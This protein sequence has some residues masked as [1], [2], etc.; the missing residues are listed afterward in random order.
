MVLLRSLFAAFVLMSVPPAMADELRVQA[1]Q[2]L[3]AAA[4]AGLAPLLAPHAGKP[5][6]INFWASWCEPC[7]EEIPALAALHA[8]GI[9]VLTVAVADRDTDAQR[10]LGGAGPGLP[11]THDRDQKLSRALGVALL[12]YSLVLDARHRVVAR[13][14]GALDWTDASVIATL[15][16]L[17]Q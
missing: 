14:E 11:L 13:M 1:P 12:P 17:M 3:P 6:L 16:R 9:R 5:L 15:N 8:R 2:A 7:R 4:A 10:F